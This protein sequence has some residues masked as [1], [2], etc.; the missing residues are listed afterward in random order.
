MTLTP[1]QIAAYLDFSDQ[2]DRIDRAN[3]LAI[4]ATAAQGDRKAIEK[5]MKEFTG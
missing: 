4:T 5:M 3:R 2:L 1:R